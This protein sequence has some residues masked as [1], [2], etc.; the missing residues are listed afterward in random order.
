[1]KLFLCALLQ[2]CCMAIFAQE[3]KEPLNV[4]IITTDGL[5]WQEVFKGADEQIINDPEFVKD[6]ALTKEMYWASTAEERRKKL[7]PFFW[8]TIAGKGQLHGNRTLNNKV[9]VGNFYKV[10]YPG[11]NEILTGYA[12]PFLGTNSANY[13]DNETLLEFINKQPAYYQSVAAFCSWNVFPFILNDTR[14]GFPVNAGYQAKNEGSLFNDIIRRVEDSVEIKEGTR[15]DQLTFLNAKQ[16]IRKNHPKMLLLGLGETDDFAHKGEY[17]QYLQQANNVDK[18]IAELWYY[19]QTDPF[20][21][22]NTVF[23]ITTDHGRGSRDSKWYS[24]SM[25]LNGAGQTWLAM[26]GSGI[27]ALGEMKTDDQ[28]YSKQ[29]A[30]TVAG[31]M[32][33]SFKANHPVATG[34]KLNSV[35]PARS[36]YFANMGFSA[37][38]LLSSQFLMFLIILSLLVRIFKMKRRFRLQLQQ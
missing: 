31:M 26:I 29:I 9:N 17:D 30:A 8:S 22:G 23:L 10:S 34:F 21:K 15:Y 32:G 6:T 1:M 14:C 35:V 5:R 4:F 3:N 7:M 19:V 37:D 11:Y 24:H 36:M 16:Y 27:N 33:L 2:L 12:D 38:I 18:M 28:I 13:N 20:Y 25:L